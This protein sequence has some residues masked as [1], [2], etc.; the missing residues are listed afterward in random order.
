MVV[1]ACRYPILPLPHG[2]YFI[3]VVSNDDID[4]VFTDILYVSFDC[5]DRE[6]TLLLNFSSP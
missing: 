6:F 4:E 3:T 5:G 2:V 1:L